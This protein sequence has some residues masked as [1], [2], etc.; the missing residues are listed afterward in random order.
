MNAGPVD[1]KRRG[2]ED[3]PNPLTGRSSKGA[4]SVV[5]PRGGRALVPE[6]RSAEAHG[7]N[8]Q[9]KRQRRGQFKKRGKLNTGPATFKFANRTRGEPDHIALSGARGIISSDQKSSGPMAKFWKNLGNRGDG[10]QATGNFTGY[11][12]TCQ[13]LNGFAK[14]PRGLAG[15]RELAPTKERGD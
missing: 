9:K 2:G 11:T 15:R 14:D 13:K 6:T 12:S 5:L 3:L 10:A 1:G 8:A 4:A 7:Q